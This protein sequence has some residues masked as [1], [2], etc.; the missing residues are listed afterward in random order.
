MGS[1]CLHVYTGNGKGKTTAALGLVCR[2]VGAGYKAAFV[3]FDKGFDGDKEFYSERN[4]LRKIKNVDLFA[5]GCSRL[6]K[7]G[8][9]RLTITDD[10]KQ[11]AQKALKCCEQL[12]QIKSYMLIVLD[13]VL[14]AVNTG[15]I[16]ND[17]LM[18]LI[19]IYKKNRVYELV[20][21][22]ANASEQIIKIA[23]LV[24]EMRNIKHYYQTGRKALKGIEF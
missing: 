6:Q 7:D 13:E 11:Q 3:Q 2:A 18:K 4:L 16:S 9:F 15:L 1:G 8:S 23:D 21:T 20:L 17:D 14:T 22:G 12:L 10:D 24:T 19:D 5:Y